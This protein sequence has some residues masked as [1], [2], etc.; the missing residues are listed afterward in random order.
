[1]ADL[2][3]KEYGIEAHGK[4]LGKTLYVACSLDG[5]VGQDLELQQQALKK[6]EGAMLS[7]TRIS[8]STDAEVDFVALIAHDPRLKVNVS[9]LRYLPD[10]KSLIYLRIPRSDFEERLVMETGNSGEDLGTDEDWHDVSMAEFLARLTAS[11]L[12]RQVSGNPLVSTFFNIRDVRGHVRDGELTLTLE[13]FEDAADAEV[14]GDILRS[15]V[16]RV[17]ADVIR[18]YNGKDFI[19]NVVVEEDSGRRLF[20]ISTPKLLALKPEKAA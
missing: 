7:A 12:Q 14:M 10:I 8:L 11:R 5:L 13:K 6:L 20:E 18:K 3:R 9:L 17:A 2:C 19:H 16:E 1:V 4:L 15:S